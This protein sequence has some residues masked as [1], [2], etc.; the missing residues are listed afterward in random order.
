[1]QH[2]DCLPMSPKDILKQIQTGKRHFSHRLGLL[3]SGEQQQA[4]GFLGSA[5]DKRSSGPG[6]CG[7]ASAPGGAVRCR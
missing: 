2:Y 6:L 5:L 4:F 7:A 1:M 3:S